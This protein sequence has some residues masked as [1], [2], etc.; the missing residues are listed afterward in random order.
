MNI[1][2]NGKL[3]EVSG[4][5]LAA[6]LDEL[7]YGGM[8]VATALNAEFVAADSRAVTR[9]Q[10]GDRLEVLAPMQGG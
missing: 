5:S 3:V 8:I 10:P 6:A 7:G 2:C 1:T 4:N 9:L